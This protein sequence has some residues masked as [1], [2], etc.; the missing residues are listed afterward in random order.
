MSSGTMDFTLITADALRSAWPRIRESLDA[1]LAK[2]PDD[3]IPEDVYHAIKCGDAAC[4]LASNDAG[5]AGILVTT[6][7]HAEFSGTP[8]LHV[9]IAHNVADA[10]VFD[11][12]MDLLR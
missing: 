2:A 6:L 9:W 7:T 5:F 11:A 10:D 8:A 12:G 1:V 4:H 3:W